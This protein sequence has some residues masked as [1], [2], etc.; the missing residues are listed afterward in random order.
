MSRLKALLPRLCSLDEALLV[1]RGELSDILP[2][3]ATSSVTVANI[4]L[5]NSSGTKYEYLTAHT[6]DAVFVEVL[7]RDN[8]K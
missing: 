7:R 3:V 6:T 4:I 8:P 1:V 2:W 5:A